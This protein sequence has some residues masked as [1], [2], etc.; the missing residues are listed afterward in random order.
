MYTEIVRRKNATR[1]PEDIN[2]FVENAVKSLRL[3]MESLETD[4][5]LRALEAIDDGLRSMRVG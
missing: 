3:I 2:A 5:T 1:S 4:A